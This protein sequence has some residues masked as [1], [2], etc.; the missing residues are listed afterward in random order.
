MQQCLAAFTD[1]SR[2]LYVLAKH[3]EIPATGALLIADRAIAPQL[4]TLGFADGVHYLSATIDDLER[5]VEEVLDDRNRAE[6]DAV[7]RR[8]HDLVHARHRTRD[9][10]DQIDAVCV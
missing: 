6:I 4:A 8:G 1:A 9:R 2:C 7:R 5:V 3:F 10:A